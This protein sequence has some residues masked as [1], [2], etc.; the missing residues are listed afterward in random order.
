[1]GDL[2]QGRILGCVCT[3]PSMSLWNISLRLRSVGAESK[4][5]GRQRR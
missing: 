4:D 1:M 2:H 5:S 3:N